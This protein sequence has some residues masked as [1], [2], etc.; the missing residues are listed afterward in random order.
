MYGL[1]KYRTKSLSSEILTHASVFY[2]LL[3]TRSI[4]FA[5]HVYKLVFYI[6]THYYIADLTCLYNLSFC[7]STLSPSHS[8][9]VCM[10]AWLRCCA[11]NREDAGSI[12]D[13]FIGIYH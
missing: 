2:C 3:T 4:T 11:T 10:C 1:L 7:L 6:Y 12:P 13:G 8:V 9:Y 5:F